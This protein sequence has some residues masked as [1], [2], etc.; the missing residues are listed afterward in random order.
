M[1]SRV[2]TRVAAQSARCSSTGSTSMLGG[3]GSGAHHPPFV[4]VSAARLLNFNT[5]TPP[6]THPSKR[7]QE[8]RAAEKVYANAQSVE[9]LSAL[10][11]DMEAGLAPGPKRASGIAV[12]ND[13]RSAP[14]SA[15]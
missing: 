7:A 14:N 12:K 5:A 6:K 2:I 15:P 3:G 4:A 10:K 9:Q 1:F 11:R 13:V 8:E